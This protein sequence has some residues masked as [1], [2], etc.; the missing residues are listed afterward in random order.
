M[1]S[2]GI[3]DSHQWIRFSLDNPTSEA[4][5]LEVR[6]FY[7]PICELYYQDS[8]GTWVRVP[9]G[10]PLD[11]T[12]RLIKSHFQVFPLPPGKRTYYIHL[13][14][15]SPPVPLFLWEKGAYQ[16]KTVR[17]KIAYGVY[18]G[19]LLFV[20]LYNLFL[21]VS[22]KNYIYFHYAVL[23]FMHI[24]IFLLVMDGMGMYLF[25]GLDLKM[26]YVI[27]PSFT[28]L[29]TSSYAILFLDLRKYA[30]TLA[31]IG[32]IAFAYLA[33][34]F[35]A[36]FYLPYLNRVAMNQINS[37]LTLFLVM[38]LG[39]VGARR[40]NKVGY[41]FAAAYLIYFLIVIIEA[42]YIQI[43]RPDYLIGI[44]HVAIAIFWEIVLLSYALSKRFQWEREE[45]MAAILEAKQQVIEKTRENERIV[46]EQNIRLEEMVNERTLQ[47]RTTN[48]QLSQSLKT[49][50]EE[51]SKAENL[52]L[53]I[54]PQAVAEELKESGRA[55]PRQFEHVTVL[56]T[57]IKNFTES[58]L[59]MTPQRLVEDLNEC[60][61]AFDAIIN[62]NGLEKIKTIGDSYM[63]AAG[64]PKE[65]EDHAIAAIQ[66]A[67]DINTFLAGW[68]SRQKK[69]GRQDWPMRI[70]IHS[71]P[72]IAG[73]VGAHKFAFDIW[74]DTVNTAAR[75]EANGQ[76]GKINISAATYEL[77]KDQFRCVPR[78]QVLVK[79]KGKLE[80]YWV[81]EEEI[82]GTGE[83]GN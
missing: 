12:D 17:L 54:L 3:T 16:V 25:Q 82:R 30:P 31:R 51:R 1:L 63:A 38:F 18:L 69:L 50:E 15:Y 75:I 45:S 26:Y 83:G 44:S 43:G 10:Y 56:F 40:G 13:Q 49:V 78:G 73:V 41:Y 52:L 5:L 4:L 72:V 71:G 81:E 57:D 59:A 20:I 36:Q 22:L 32:W 47:L 46:R 8:A 37:L 65:R 76:V 68:R 64:L 7:F 9:L 42:T 33:F 62:R 35:L 21:F 61:Q 6:H 67:I 70:G 53:N 48:I 77:V 55:E 14:T 19:F 28:T 58:T 11:V 29:V 79:G 74:G 27:V 24:C 60:F 2:F 66:A 80:M 39:I 34:Y 23:V